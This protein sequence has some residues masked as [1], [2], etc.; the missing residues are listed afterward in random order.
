MVVGIKKKGRTIPFGYKSYNNTK[1]LYPISSQLKILNDTLIEIK[2]GKLSIRNASKTLEQKTNRYLSHPGLLKIMNRK[3]PG[4][5]VI[6]NKEKLKIKNEKIKYKKLLNLK[7]KEEKEIERIRLR[8]LK[9]IK[10]HNCTLCNEKRLISEFKKNK[11]K[12]C[13]KCK[14]IIINKDPNLYLKCLI[15]KKKKN[16]LEFTGSKGH[17]IYQT[18]TCNPC[19]RSYHRLWNK[20]NRDKRLKINRKSK[21]FSDQ[22][23]NKNKTLW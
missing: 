5:Q 6:A 16:F 20:N 4:W 1:L 15:C 22:D 3:F 19:F 21:L 7:I 12:Y 14:I 11:A 17:N 10:Y 8:E 2:N 13:D 23:I 18:K 9:K